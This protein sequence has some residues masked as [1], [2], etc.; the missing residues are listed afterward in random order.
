MLTTCL[1][2]LAFVITLD[3][4]LPLQE[5]ATHP[6]LAFTTP[7]PFVSTHAQT[8]KIRHQ[9]SHTTLSINARKTHLLLISGV[10]LYILTVPLEGAVSF[11]T[12]EKLSPA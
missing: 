9:H 8:H 12:V 7:S 6:K 2:Q 10:F 4:P 3:A 1:E 5:G 11:S